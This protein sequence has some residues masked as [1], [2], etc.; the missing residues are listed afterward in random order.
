MRQVPVW[1][2]ATRIFHWVLV[3]AVVTCLVTGDDEGLEFFVHAY[4]GY[5]VA[6]LVG[7]RIVW[8][9]VGSPRS[10]F[11]DFAYGA[12]SVTGYSVGLLRL[13]P[14]R[15]VGHNPLGG[16]MVILMVVV[17]V[18]TSLTGFLTLADGGRAFEE[19]HES[20]GSFMQVL[21]FIHIAGVVVD[22]VLTGD[23]IV[24]AMITGRKELSEEAAAREAPLVGPGRA[25]L[26]ALLVLVAGAVVF[27]QSDFSA[28]VVA[29]AERGEGDRGGSRGED[30]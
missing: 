8:G 17:L 30:D 4:A 25:V 10:R 16:W 2:L 20:L 26:V 22:R 23:K 19:V 14:D 3:C 9:V 1:D 28:K 24:M 12:A 18:G 15:H 29:K 7:F 11:A 27:Q 6:L 13:R 21:V 5:L